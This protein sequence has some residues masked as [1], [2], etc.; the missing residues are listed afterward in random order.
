MAGPVD[1]SAIRRRGSNVAQI[2]VSVVQLPNIG[3]GYW[4]YGLVSGYL[5]KEIHVAILNWRPAN[6]G[7]EGRIQA[8]SFPI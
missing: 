3:R 6:L 4:P 1:F 5:C 2:R 8:A 7:R